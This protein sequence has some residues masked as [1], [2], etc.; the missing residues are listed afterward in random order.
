MGVVREVF[1]VA[2][3]I[4]A[5]AILLTLLNWRD[6]GASR[7]HRCVLDQLAQPDLRGRFGVSI[8]YAVFSR[9]HVVS[10]DL[11]ASTPS[12]VWDIFTRLASRLPPR[13]RLVVHST[14][15]SGCTRP[16]AL[17]TT[18][19]SASSHVPRRSLLTR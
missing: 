13:V 4:G 15:D 17:E 3:I 8:Q 9:R 11:L 5:V 1:G 2:T 16:L 14:L 18:T 6:R 12:E 10:V 7:L 19:G